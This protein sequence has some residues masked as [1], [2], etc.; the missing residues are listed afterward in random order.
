MVY[1]TKCTKP[2]SLDSGTCP[3]CGSDLSSEQVEV[4]PPKE[5]NRS[6]S[7]SDSIPFLDPFQSIASE[8]GSA[9]PPISGLELETLPP[10]TQASGKVGPWAKEKN[11]DF[12]AKVLGKFGEAEQ[13]AVGSIKYWMKVRQRLKDLDVEERKAARTSKLKADKFL[14]LRAELGRKAFDLKL[15]DGEIGK[16]IEKAIK[17]E[18]A[19]KGAA[20]RTEST[21]A[22]A[23]VGDWILKSKPDIPELKPL[24]K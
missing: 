13:G 1:C 10:G 14:K 9:P 16:L 4:Q 22:W 6:E 15:T 12:E 20:R 17:S 19:S 11:E 8:L 7:G 5:M 18:P 3:H 21:S 2:S 23:D 24:K